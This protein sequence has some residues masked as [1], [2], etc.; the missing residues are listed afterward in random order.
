MGDGTNIDG[1]VDHI[2]DIAG[3]VHPASGIDGGLHPRGPVISAVEQQPKIDEGIIQGGDITG[4][5][6]PEVTLPAALD[7][8]TEMDAGLVH[9][10]NIAGGREGEVTMHPGLIHGGNMEG[11]RHG[12]CDVH[13]QGVLHDATGHE[14]ALVRAGNIED[15]GQSEVT[16]QGVLGGGTA[17]GGAHEVRMQAAGAHE[18]EIE[19]GGQL[20]AGNQHG[21]GR[22]GHE[23]P[24]AITGH[25]D[26][27]AH[28]NG[29]VSAVAVTQAAS[30][31]SAGVR[32]HLRTSIIWD[33]GS[34]GEVD[35]RKVWFCK[36]CTLSP[37]GILKERS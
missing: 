15:G 10:G 7:H 5:V 8:D 22:G 18:V 37:L 25:E 26:P 27:G 16:M 9:G 3:Y 23:H 2:S 35:G 29:G 6:Q 13:M 30:Q 24:A 19:Q 20:E 31:R 11:E 17:G 34:E 32:I 12:E 28:V 21:V 1:V 33:H 4:G 36:Y 14:I